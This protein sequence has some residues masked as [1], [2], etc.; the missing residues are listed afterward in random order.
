MIARLFTHSRTV[1][2]LSCGMEPRR[3]RLCYT[4]FSCFLVSPSPKTQPGALIYLF[5][6]CV[7]TYLTQFFNFSSLS[8]HHM[9]HVFFPHRGAVCLKQL[10][11][12]VLRSLV[13]DFMC[14]VDDT[15]KDLNDSRTPFI[16]FIVRRSMEDYPK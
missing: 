12:T 1:S 14:D 11:S 8:L 10:Q 4:I 2:L 7:Y 15:M 16:L 3:I 6:S 13:V 5:P 9:Q